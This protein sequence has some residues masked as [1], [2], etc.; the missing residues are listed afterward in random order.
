MANDNNAVLDGEKKL[1]RNDGESSAAPSVAGKTGGE[2]GEGGNNVAAADSGV[3]VAKDRGGAAIVNQQDA[4]R[5]IR[6]R[7]KTSTADIVIEE[8]YVYPDADERKE[9]SGGDSSGVEGVAAGG[10]KT[11]LSSHQSQ[12]QPQSQSQQSSSSVSLRDQSSAERRERETIHNSILFNKVS[13]I[14]QKRASVL[15]D[16]EERNFNYKNVELLRGFISEKGKIL[17]SRLTGLTRKQQ[18]RMAACIKLARSLA[19]LPFEVKY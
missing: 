6:N 14:D 18:R 7:P 19:L 16:E 8:L 5:A 11:S 17:P 9:G 1:L 4:I 10:Q 2:A 15:S 12:S 13:C 3:V